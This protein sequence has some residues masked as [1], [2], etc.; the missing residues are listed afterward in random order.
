MIPIA[1]LQDVVRQS[2]ATALLNHLW[3]STMIVL[4]MWILAQ[5]LRKNR[6]GTRYWLWMAASIKFL[7]PFSVLIAAGESIRTAMQSPMQRFDVAAA[8]DQFA[9]PFP[10]SPPPFAIAMQTGNVHHG[11]SIAPFLLVIWACGFLAVLVSWGRSWWRIH[12]A[13]QQALPLSLPLAV[14]VLSSKSLL[15]PGVFGLFRPVLLLPEGILDH[16]EKAQLEAILAHESC[17]V[18]RRDNLTFAIHMVVEAL[19]W[20]HPLVWWIRTRLVAERELAC[21]E[22]VLQAGSEAEVYAEG[23]LNVCKFYVESPLACVS[24]V[25][26]SD[27]KKRIVRIM[28]EKVELRLGLGRKILLAAAGVAIVALPIVLGLGHTVELLAQSNADAAAAS[29]PKYEVATIKPAK[30]DEPGRMLMFNPS[31]VKMKGMPIEEVLRSAFGVEEDRLLGLP[32]WAKSSRFDIDAKVDA[33]DAPKLEGLTPDQ[34][35]AMLLPLFVD[36]F[37]LKY[38]HEVKELPLYALVLAKNGPKLTESKQADPSSKDGPH[39]MMMMGRGSLDGQGTSIETLTHVI[40]MH[41]GRTVI[42]KTGLTGTYDFKLTWT[43]DEGAGP[44]MKG[45]GGGGAPG[46]ESAPPPDAGGP[47]L[48][49]ALQEQLGLKLESE[50]GPVDVIVIDHIDPPSPN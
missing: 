29:L 3:Q 22:A 24:G 33:A 41:V 12:R 45:P 39:R 38:H 18:R 31:G 8:V 16:L 43:P 9:E 17:H 26:G 46:T 35:G 13:V 48:L 37:N 15:E 40:S 5:A 7:V 11:I 30:D 44:M 6:A 10:A 4:T 34:R 47:T 2:Y 1:N 36:R 21:D 14:P 32:G 42:D 27:L 49:T 50:K 19:F 23:I 25:S 28:S 20:F